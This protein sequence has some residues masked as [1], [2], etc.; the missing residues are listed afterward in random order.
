MKY[1]RSPTAPCNSME[2]DIGDAKEFCIDFFY[3]F[4]NRSHESWLESKSVLEVYLISSR[5]IYLMFRKESNQDNKWV[6][7]QQQ[8]VNENFTEGNPLNWK[9]SKRPL[10][11][12]QSV[13]D[14][15]AHFLAFM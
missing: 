9:V 12:P 4:H 11:A 3:K 14:K 6:R 2:F 7:I 8:F 5:E 10:T 15:C 13:H 1:Q